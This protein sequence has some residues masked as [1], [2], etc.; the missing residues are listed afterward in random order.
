MGNSGIYSRLQTLGRTSPELK[1]VDVPQGTVVPV[2]SCLHDQRPGWSSDGKEVFL[3]TLRQLR[4]ARQGSLE[5]W[6]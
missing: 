5:P 1:E 3:L 6:V 4:C 2:T